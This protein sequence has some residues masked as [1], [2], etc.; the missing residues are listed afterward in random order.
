MRHVKQYCVALILLGVL[1]CAASGCGPSYDYAGYPSYGYAPYSYGWGGYDPVFVTHH[2]WEDHSGYGGHHTEF[3][4][5]GGEREGGGGFHGGGGGFHG[6][7][8]GFHGGGGFG[9]GHGGGG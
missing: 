5:G 7:G 4:H 8:G 6:G 3:Y 1:A 9:G 2:R